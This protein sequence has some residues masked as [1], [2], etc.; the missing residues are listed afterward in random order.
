MRH[1]SA[2]PEVLEC[3]YS[4][5]GTIMQKE[6]G[7]SVKSGLPEG[8]AVLGRRSCRILKGW[9][10]GVMVIAPLDSHYRK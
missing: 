10:R 9:C 4:N 6:G 5:L 7:K 3:K 1:G 8:A 2:M